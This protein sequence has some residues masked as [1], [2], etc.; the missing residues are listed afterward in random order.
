MPKTFLTILHDL[1]FVFV[2]FSVNLSFFASI[3]EDFG[4]IPNE[5]IRSIDFDVDFGPR[6]QFTIYSSHQGYQADATHYAHV[7]AERQTCDILGYF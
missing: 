2:L 6:R 7:K 5:V 3:E 1:E 4:S